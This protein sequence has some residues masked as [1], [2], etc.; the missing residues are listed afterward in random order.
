[1][2]EQ[3][4]NCP[5]TRSR[6]TSM[7]IYLIAALTFLF[8]WLN[9][10]SNLPGLI[11]FINLLIISLISLKPPRIPSSVE[12]KWSMVIGIY[13]ALFFIVYIPTAIVLTYLVFRQQLIIDAILMTVAPLA[14]SIV[15]FGMIITQYIKY[16][17][18]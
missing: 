1:M 4:F 18:C 6:L 8:A 15:L 9:S 12:R 14:L 16:G 11:A 7:L 10:T 2:N 17:A 5:S 13:M 3:G